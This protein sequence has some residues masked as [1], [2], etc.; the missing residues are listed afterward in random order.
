MT[1]GLLTCGSIFSRPVP[2]CALITEG[3]PGWVG[4]V[5]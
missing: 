2:V 1:D 3:W 4:L 5:S